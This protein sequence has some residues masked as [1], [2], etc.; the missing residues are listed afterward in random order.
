[1]S[2]AEILTLTVIF[3][4]VALLVWLLMPPAKVRAYEIALDDPDRRQ[5]FIPAEDAEDERAA[6]H[7][8]MLPRFGDAFPGD[9]LGLTVSSVVVEPQDGFGWLVTVE[10]GFNE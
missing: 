9:D 3:A 5:F 8:H 2:I 7:H 10:Y 6:M 1:M 4:P